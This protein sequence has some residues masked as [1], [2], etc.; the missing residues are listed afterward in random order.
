MRINDFRDGKIKCCHARPGQ[1]VRL[2]DNEGNCLG[3]FLVCSAGILERELGS[4]GL[5]KADKPVFLV[6]LKTGVARDFPHL[7]SRLIEVAED[8]SVTLSEGP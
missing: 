7:S 2:Y 5:Y 8:A 3:L 1:A 4:S 6:D